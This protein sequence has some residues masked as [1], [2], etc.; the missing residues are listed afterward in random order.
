MNDFIVITVDI[1]KSQHLTT[2]EMSKVHNEIENTFNEIRNTYIP[3]LLTIG[4]TAGD[5]F[6]VVLE[7]SK[8][9][10]NLIY[11]LRAKIP[12]DFW[13]GIGVGVVEEPDSR[14][15]PNQMWGP[16]FVHAREALTAAKKN[17]SDIAIVTYDDKINNR[18]NTILGLVS[19]MRKNMTDNQRKMVDLYNYYTVTK[20][21]Q[22]QR[23]LANMLNVSD[24]MVSKTLRNSGHEHLKRGESLVQEMVSELFDPCR[25]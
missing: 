8:E 15:G 24:A 17:N 4:F 14:R 21:I 22:Y 18:L 23:E 6:E 19:F 16:A 20:K 13:I 11:H 5:E 3:I 2:S 1:K 9:L 12:I 10:F 7:P 25:P